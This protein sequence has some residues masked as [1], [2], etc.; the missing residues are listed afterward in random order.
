MSANFL[1]FCFVFF[2]FQCS[3]VFVFK[4]LFSTVDKSWSS[5]LFYYLL[6]HPRKIT[7][8]FEPTDRTTRTRQEHDKSTGI[9]K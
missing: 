3:R 6:W 2:F 8:Y 7:E 5:I 9:I 1:G 4:I